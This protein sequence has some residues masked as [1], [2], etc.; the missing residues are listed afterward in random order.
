MADKKEGKKE[1]ADSKEALAKKLEERSRQITAQLEK[2]KAVRELH[3]IEQEIKRGV[4]E[5]SVE[6]IQ[7]PPDEK[8]KEPVKEVAKEVKPPK[9][10][11]A[12]VKDIK[13]VEQEL[14]RKAREQEQARELEKVYP[15]A[16]GVK[17]AREFARKRKFT[18]TWDLALGLKGINLKRPENRF[19]IELHLPAGR[20][21]PVRVGVIADALATE[22]KKHADVVVGKDEIGPLA[23]DKK[24]LKRLANEVEWLLGEVSLMPVIGK[25]F[26]VVLGPRGKVPKP[27]PPKADLKALVERARNTVRVVLKDSPAIH[28]TLGTEDMKDEQLMK[29]LQAAVAAVKEKLPKGMNNVRSMHLKL[30]MGKPVKLEVK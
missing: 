4:A 5:R 30:T 15:L 2:G 6:S 10:A 29:T 25:S 17:K 11:K 18:Q 16:E 14:A 24:K 3:E 23:K 8:P 7:K 20:G 27:V 22:A 26:G 1:K 12:A 28:I 13:K 21:K 9:K 19:S